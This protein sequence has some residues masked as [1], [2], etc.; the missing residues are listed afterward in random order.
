M[1]RDG[2]A[3]LLLRWTKDLALTP[4]T[5]FEASASFRAACRAAW[6]EDLGWTRASASR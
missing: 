6:V 5:A 4:G 2:D 1:D 3:C